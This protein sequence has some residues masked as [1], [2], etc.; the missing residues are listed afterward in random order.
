MD[1]VMRLFNMNE[2]MYSLDRLGLSESERKVVDDIIAKPSG[3]VMIVG[4]TGSGK[5]T[6]LYSMLKSLSNDERKIITIED[7]VEYQFKGITQIS[8]RTSEEAKESIF[9]DQLRAV[10]RLDPDIIMVGEIRDMDTARAA[11]QAAMTG[12]LVLS[13]FHA[14]SAAAALTRLADIINQNPLY[15]SA[16]RL[17]MA[18]RLVRKLNP[19]FREAYAASESELQRLSEIISTLPVNI[20][21]PDLSNLQLYKPQVTEANPYGY[22]GQLAIREQFM[23]SDAVRATLENKEKAVT[24]N[25]IESAAIN[26]GMQTMIQDAALKVVSGVTTLEEMYRVL[27]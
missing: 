16:I 5:T 6:T 13:T 25:D 22:N 24:T 11:L 23:M 1:V 8:V 9:A 19:D 3:L 4:P 18:Q 20:P 21:R 7:P 14:N 27:G 10:L 17:V 2:A 26:S 15:I 12:H